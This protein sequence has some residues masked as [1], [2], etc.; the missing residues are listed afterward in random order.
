MTPPRRRW[1]TFVHMRDI[2]II[3]SLCLFAAA[4][5]SWGESPTGQVITLKDGTVLKGQLIQVSQ[6]AYII[7]TQNLGRVSVPVS[8]LLSITTASA[9][10]PLTAPAASLG[11]AGGLPGFAGFQQELMSD[12]A[13]TAEVADLM[14]DPEI[15]QLLTQ[16]ALLQDLMTMDPGQIQ[17]NPAVQRLLENPQFQKIMAKVQEKMLTSPTVGKLLPTP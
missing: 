2:L 1:Y 15:L 4:A 11:A 13:F 12:P 16:P 17:G 10:T 5:P 7:E 3:T 9:S 6:N 8:E 14:K